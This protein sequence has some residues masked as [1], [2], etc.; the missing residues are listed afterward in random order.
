[1][2][3]LVLPIQT[4]SEANCR[5][6][7]RAK[8]KRVKQQRLIARALTPATPI[9]CVV[10]LVRV[11][12]RALDDDNLRS[13]LKAVRDGVA[14]KLG[15]NDRDPSVQWRYDQARGEPCVHVTLEATARA[16]EAA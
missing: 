12:Y 16:G 2:I 6:H 1:M 14:D 9:S 5:D 11:S 13:A 15:V 10:T 7:W 8:A 4:V 3:S